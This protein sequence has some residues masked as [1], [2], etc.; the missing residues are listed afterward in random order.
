MRASVAWAKRARR[1][2]LAVLAYL[3]ER[4][5]Q[6]AADFNDAV[7]RRIERLE[8]FPESG[9]RL[10]EKPD[11]TPPI[12]ELLVGEYRLVYVFRAPR[13]EIVAL[14]HGR[15]KFTPGLLH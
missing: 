14:F 15:R 3:K 12:R 5:P 4:S 8:R 11:S 9:R 2:F 10:P 1:D 13:L 6:A 7:S